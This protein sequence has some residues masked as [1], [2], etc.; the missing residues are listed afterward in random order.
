M[1]LPAAVITEMRSC[2]NL[3]EADHDFH[4]NS[5]YATQYYIEVDDHGDV[6][7]AIVFDDNLGQFLNCTVELKLNGERCR[8][9]KEHWQAMAELVHDEEERAERAW[10]EKE[11]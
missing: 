3:V 8:E 4:F 2:K 10:R 7:R 6:V 5:D 9:I 1:T 11:A